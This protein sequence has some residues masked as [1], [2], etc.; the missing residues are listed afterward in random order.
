MATGSFLRYSQSLGV[1]NGSLI[2]ISL[3]SAFAQSK[4]DCNFN[5]YKNLKSMWGTVMLVL[6]AENLKA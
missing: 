5:N 4:V 1:G 3:Y 6:E 2:S